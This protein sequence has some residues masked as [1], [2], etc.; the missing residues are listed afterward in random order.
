MKMRLPQP[1]QLIPFS[2]GVN[3]S[4]F[5]QKVHL[6]STSPLAILVPSMNA[7]LTICFEPVLLR[8]NALL[9]KTTSKL[10]HVQGALAMAQSPSWMKRDA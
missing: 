9:E 7:D 4:M 10:R 2:S 1:L 5:P 8:I 6:Y 3:D